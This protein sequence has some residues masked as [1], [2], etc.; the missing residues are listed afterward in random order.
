MRRPRIRNFTPEASEQEKLFGY[1]WD[2][3][4]FNPQ[5]RWL[6]ESNLRADPDP[7]TELQEMLPLQM[8]GASGKRVSL[9]QVNG[10]TRRPG[11]GRKAL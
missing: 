3:S 4:L 10:E 5:G 7:V 2:T 8:G 6:K 1:W 11:V 9:P